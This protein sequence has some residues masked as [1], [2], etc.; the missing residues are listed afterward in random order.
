MSQFRLIALAALLA[1]GAAGHLAN[2]APPAPA[3]ANAPAQ[4]KEYAQANGM[5]SELSGMRAQDSTAKSQGTNPWAVMSPSGVH[6]QS[7]AGFV[8]YH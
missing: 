1:I 4:S 6:F 5:G 3:Q 8:G 2:A 7:R